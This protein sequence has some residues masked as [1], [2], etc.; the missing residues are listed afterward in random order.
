[1]GANKWREE[2][3][4]PPEEARRRRLL[5]GERRPRQLAR[6]ATARSTSS[7]PRTAPR[8]TSSSIRAIPVPTR[9]GAVCCN[10]KI[11]PWGPMDQR[12]V[13]QRKDVLV[14]TTRR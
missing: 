3:E 4:W 9:G 7:A 13:E 14:Y 2:R 10:P 5:P 11:F 1:M 8:T 6:R 12:P